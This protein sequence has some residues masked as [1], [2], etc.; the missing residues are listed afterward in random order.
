MTLTRLLLRALVMILASAASTAQAAPSFTVVTA[1]SG[2]QALRES[3][4]ADF[5]V[6][7]ILRT[8]AQ[9]G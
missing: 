4:P 6:D 5:E 3:K 1:D 9:A 7:P 2:I 8:S